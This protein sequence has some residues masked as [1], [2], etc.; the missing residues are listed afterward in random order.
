M[1]WHFQK[2][3][4]GVSFK[5]SKYNK[6]KAVLKCYCK[7]CPGHLTKGCSGIKESYMI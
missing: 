6:N 5:V 1:N 7:L 4:F 2:K 3:K